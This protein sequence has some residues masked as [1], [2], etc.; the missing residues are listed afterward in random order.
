M[1]NQILPA[2]IFGFL[3][4]IAESGLTEISHYVSVMDIQ[5]FH[6][7]NLSEI[8]EE[9]SQLIIKTQTLMDNP[10]PMK[11]NNLNLKTNLNNDVLQQYREAQQKS[12]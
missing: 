9:L 5:Q 2:K 8:Q 11:Q 1:H 12:L 3:G 4:N 6:Q 10:I 7:T